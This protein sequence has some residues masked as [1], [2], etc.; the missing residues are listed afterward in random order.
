MRGL[1]EH[2]VHTYKIERSYLKTGIG[3]LVLIVWNGLW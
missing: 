1:R 3:K 2:G